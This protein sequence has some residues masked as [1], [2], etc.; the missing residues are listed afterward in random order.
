[1]LTRTAFRQASSK[2]PD[3]DARVLIS[4]LPISPHHHL[5]TGGDA[6]LTDA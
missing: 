2:P 4:N 1:M 3:L 5:V 6:P